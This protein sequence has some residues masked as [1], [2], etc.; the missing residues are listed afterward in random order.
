MPVSKT[1]AKTPTFQPPGWRRQNFDRFRLRSMLYRSVPEVC[2]IL[3][4]AKVS[5]RLLRSPQR[6]PSILIGESCTKLRDFP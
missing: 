4:T 3:T 5:K 1:H 6:A 2:F